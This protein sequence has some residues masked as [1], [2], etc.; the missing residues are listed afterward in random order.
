MSKLRQHLEQLRGEHLAA[1]YPGNLPADVERMSRSRWRLAAQLVTGAAAIAALVAM[2]VWLGNA[3][4][5]IEQ[6]S[7]EQKVTESVPFALGTFAALS[8]SLPHPPEGVSFA[9]EAPPLS[10]A[11]P[12][13]PSLFDLLNIET[14]KESI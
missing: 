13:F 6:A 5:V 3:R 10:T 1:Q 12:P 8:H 11:M 4:V 9:I 14:E 2:I 7:T